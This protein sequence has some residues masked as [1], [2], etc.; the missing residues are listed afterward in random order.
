MILKWTTRALAVPAPRSRI[1]AAIDR[2]R[3]KLAGRGEERKGASP[4]LSSI[5]SSRQRQIE[6]TER[7]VIM[8]QTWSKQKGVIEQ[9][10]GKHR[11]HTANDQGKIVQLISLAYLTLCSS[12]PLRLLSWLR[13][14]LLLEEGNIRRG[15]RACSLPSAAKRGR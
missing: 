7:E 4:L 3:E 5:F 6:R 13:A 1:C 10:S 11:Y 9:T 12:T 15:W 2:K 8:H 14:L